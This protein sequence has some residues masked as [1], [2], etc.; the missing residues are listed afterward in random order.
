M[1]KHLLFLFATL[2]PL[3]ASAEKVEIEGIWYNLNESALQAEVT[4]K[5]DSYNSF[6]DEYSG[7]ITLSATVTH[8]GMQY[9]VTSIGDGAFYECTSLTSVTLPKGVTSIGN[10]AFYNCIN[11]TSINIPEGIISIGDQAFQS[12]SIGGNLTTPYSCK[13]LEISA[14]YA[15]ISPV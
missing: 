15:Q 7:P 14:F 5:G 8:N 12:S 4:Y 10:S 3:A 11:L 1:R 6:K 13:Y 9:S 2:L